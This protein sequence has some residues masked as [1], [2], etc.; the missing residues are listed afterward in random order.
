MSHTPY[1]DARVK[2]LLD[3]E[4]PCT[5]IC[6]VTG[7]IWDVT[8]ADIERERK[9]S[10]P[11]MR[12]SPRTYFK[13]WSQLLTGYSWWWNKHTETGKPVLTHIHP[14]TF[15]KVIEDEEWHTRDFSAIQIGIDRSRS[16]FDQIYELAT[17]VPMSAYKNFEKPVN[18]IARLSFGDKN[19]FFMEGTRSKDSLYC[20]DTLDVEDSIEVCW[21][22]R[23]QQSY[24]VMMSFDLNRCVAARSSRNS[25]HCDFI[26]DCWNCESCF[27]AFNR[28][29]AKYLWDG[30]QLSEEEWRKRR[31]ALRLGDHNTY[32][33][34]YTDFLC[35]V[36][37]EAVWPENFNLKV[38]N[39]TG[40]YLTNCVNCEHSWFS[41][42][43]K[44][45][46]WTVWGNL[47]TE[48][49][50]LGA[51]VASTRCFGSM[52]S[53]HSDDCRFCWAVQRCQR[54]EYCIEC[55]D[56]EDCFGCVGIK[57]KRFHI[58][59]KEYPEEVY[60][61]KLDELKCVMLKLGEYGLP[62][63]RR[64][65]QTPFR[66]AGGAFYQ[67]VE[68]G[69]YEK[70]SV[71]DFDPAFDDAFGNWD[72]KDLHDLSEIPDHVSDAD[73]VKGRVFLDPALNRPFTLFPAE[74]KL[75]KKLG[76]RVSRRHFTSRVEDLWREM[77]IFDFE[78]RVCAKCSASLTVAKNKTFPE[79]KIYCRACYL[80]YLETRG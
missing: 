10:I 15:W 22:G 63:Y 71:M 24:N 23:I 59:N 41:D 54:L 43:A 33:R 14:H 67:D 16:V 58:F 39:S 12:I 7:E 30:E 42:G 31:E 44:D 61:Q 69:D 53:V 65:I 56:C 37:T 25:L 13:L 66:H 72:R 20:T 4:R 2:A 1:F 64:F 40:E 46:W 51:D 9:F 34:L 60:W 73:S 11:P 35:R 80:R 47:G 78:S 8:E 77:N 38:E 5:R 32:E 50:A 52:I 19:S 17:R 3:A 76:V 26:F 27:M 45:C 68:S 57:R 18:S 74:I 70:Q 6:E 29:H 28:R 49:C 62:F 48:T 55:Y 79:R 21:S 75:Y 36:G